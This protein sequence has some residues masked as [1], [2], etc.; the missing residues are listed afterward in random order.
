MTLK[1]KKPLYTVTFTLSNEYTQ[2]KVRRMHRKSFVKSI[3]KSQNVTS[4][5][6][7]HM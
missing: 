6:L 7:A 3:L 1:K 4:K 5:V 2:K